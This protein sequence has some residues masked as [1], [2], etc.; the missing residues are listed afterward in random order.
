MCRILKVSESA[1]YSSQQLKISSRKEK[2]ERVKQAIKTIYEQSRF[3]YGSVRIHKELENQGYR[4]SQPTVAKYMREMNIRSIISKKYKICT[5]DSKHSFKIADN[6]LDRNFTTTSANQ[7]WVSDITYILT[8]EGW[9]FLTIVLDLYDRKVIGWSFSER[10]HTSETT[11]AAFNIA[12]QNRPI[13]ETQKLI[14]HSDRGS[15]YACDELKKALACFKNVQQSMSRKGNCWDN[16]PAESFFKTLK[17]ELV[18]HYEYETLKEAELSIFEYIEGF[19]NKCRRH[20]ALNNDTIDE[21]W[22]KQNSLKQVA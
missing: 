3:R 21:F 8:A 20:S 6:V 2:N 7:A 15:Q 16:A 12:K 4:V 5:T 18:Y 11:L 19:Y 1:Y 10:M 14:F 13:W 9:L 22:A 17:T